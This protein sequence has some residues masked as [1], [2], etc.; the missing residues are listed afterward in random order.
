M[1]KAEVKTAQ[2]KMISLSITIDMLLNKVSYIHTLIDSECLCF[3]MMTKRT[4]EWNKLEQ[5]SVPSQK[6]INVMSKPGMID[7]IA[8]AYININEHTEICYFY[9]KGNNL[10]YDLILS[11][12]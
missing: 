9:I 2:K 5:F 4:V 8:K 3:D 10:K 11:R 1:K 12:L 7:E 6:V